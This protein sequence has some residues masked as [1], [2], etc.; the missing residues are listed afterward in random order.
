MFSRVFYEAARD[1]DS[2]PPPRT[3]HV[4]AC[5]PRECAALQFVARAA[6]SPLAS[7]VGQRKRRGPK[8]PEEPFAAGPRASPCGWRG[9][10]PQWPRS[11]RLGSASGSNVAAA[12]ERAQGPARRDPA[13]SEKKRRRSGAGAAASGAVRGRLGALRQWR[14][15]EPGALRS[16]APA[17]ALAPAPLPPG[18]APSQ[19]SPLEDPFGS[20]RASAGRA[21]QAPGGGG[22][23]PR[24]SRSSAKFFAAIKA[25]APAAA[26]GQAADHRRHGARLGRRLLAA[27]GLVVRGGLRDAAVRPRDG[28][29]DPAA[30]RRAEGERADVHP[31]PRRRHRRQ[32]ARR[33]RPRRGPRG[34]RRA[35]PRHARRRASAGRWRKPPTATCCA[36]SPTSASS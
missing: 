32:V 17:P 30:P 23:S 13:P 29:R 10:T 34:A 31:L 27:V 24:S 36:R 2:Q 3:D 28:P 4:E 33:E 35:D 20:A 15:G 6:R 11:L 9:L 26:E 8:P 12:L 16:R 7:A 18:G 14:C 25:G 22:G 21:A 5:R 1:L 19:D